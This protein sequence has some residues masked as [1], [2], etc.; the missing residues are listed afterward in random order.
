MT[1]EKMLPAYEITLRELSDGKDDLVHPERG[2]DA[3][4]LLIKP[5]E[6]YPKWEQP[7][8]RLESNTTRSGSGRLVQI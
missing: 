2:I 1:K 5:Q 3:Y 7:I 8:T 4:E 6:L